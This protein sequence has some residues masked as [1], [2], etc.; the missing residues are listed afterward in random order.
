MNPI[1]LR[2]FFRLRVRSRGA[3]FLAAATPGDSPNQVLQHEIMAGA[4]YLLAYLFYIVFL[5]HF[6]IFFECF[7]FCT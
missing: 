1:W 4:A 3:S 5:N 6:Q 7:I 2:H